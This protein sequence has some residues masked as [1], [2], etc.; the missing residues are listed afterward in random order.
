MQFKSVKGYSGSAQF[1][2][3]LLFSLLGFILAIGLQFIVTFKMLP[4][5][6]SIADPEAIKAA[7]LEPRNL[8]YA[9]FLQVMSTFIL[10]FI[11]A[12]LYSFVANGRNLFWLGFNKYFT[13]GQVVIAFL[14]TFAAGIALTPLTDM[15]KS[16]VAHFPSFD[17]MARNLELL[18][19][20]QARALSNLKSWPEFFMAIVIMAFFPAMFEEVF[21]R[22]TMQNLLARWWNKPILA[23]IVTSLIFSLIH[24]SVYLFLSR[25]ALGFVLGLIY[26]KTKNIWLPISAHFLN[27]LIVL[28]NLFWMYKTGKKVDLAAAD[29]KFDWW[30]SIPAFI[31]MVL[32][33]VLLNRISARYRQKVLEKEAALLAHDSMTDPFTK[34]EVL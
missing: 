8:S 34:R 17:A 25:A 24:T 21:F 29:P 22:G 20:E 31:V 18:Y 23:I 14:I 11:P 15:T 16:I 30:I 1:G 4:P 19:D 5:G 12:V 3:L 6:A 10:L 26:H 2:M 9:R 32:L 13:I 7:M 33:F 28:V 27:N